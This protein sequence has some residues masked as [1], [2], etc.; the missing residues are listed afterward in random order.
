MQKNNNNKIILQRLAVLVRC[1]LRLRV[2]KLVMSIFYKMIQAIKI[3]KCKK[4]KL[5]QIASHQLC[6]WE[7]EVLVKFTWFR[8]RLE[9]IIM[10]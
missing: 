9:A 2:A 1:Y 8:R 7:K 10:R 5:V 4:K 3:L 6:F